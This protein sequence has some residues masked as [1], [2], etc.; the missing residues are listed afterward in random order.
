MLG[1]KKSF[2]LFVNINVVLFLLC[3]CVMEDVEE[4]FVRTPDSRPLLVYLN[5]EE[6]V[7]ECEGASCLS[8]ATRDLLEKVNNADKAAKVKVGHTFCSAYP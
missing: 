4:A 2:L 8:S 3:S 6:K 7:I 5:M 1:G